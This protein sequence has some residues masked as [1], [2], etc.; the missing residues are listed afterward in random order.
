MRRRGVRFPSLSPRLLSLLA[1]L[2]A[3]HAVSDHPARA[4][5]PPRTSAV[6]HDIFIH[7]ADLD[8]GCAAKPGSASQFRADHP[9]WPSGTVADA[10]CGQADLSGG[11][12]TYRAR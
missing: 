7:T 3:A 12:R 4:V 8:I 9:S 2:A 1:V 5:G 10:S 11:P 6:V